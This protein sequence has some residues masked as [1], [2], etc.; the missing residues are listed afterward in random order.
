MSSLI[1]FNSK[2]A[3]LEHIYIM[4]TLAFLLYHKKTYLSAV[5]FFYNSG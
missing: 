3:T 4:L 1:T 5:F 2:K